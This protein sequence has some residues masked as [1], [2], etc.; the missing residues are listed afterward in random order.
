MIWF[1]KS[2]LVVIWT[3]A[4]TTRTTKTAIHLLLPQLTQ[5]RAQ[6]QLN[7]IMEKNMKKHHNK[8][9]YKRQETYS[10]F[11]S[12]R[13]IPFKTHAQAHMEIKKEYSKNHNCAEATKLNRNTSEKYP[14]AHNLKA[15]LDFRFFTSQI[16]KITNRI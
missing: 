11:N 5:S 7:E 9:G 10:R 13:K 3:G 16:I 8:R 12:R 1:S 4:A 15:D 14:T 2:I 6:Q